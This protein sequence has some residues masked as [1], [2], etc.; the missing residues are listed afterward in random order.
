M[1]ARCL[2]M[3][4]KERNTVKNKK[5]DISYRYLKYNRLR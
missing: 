3:Q 4:I 2:I 5:E 1:R